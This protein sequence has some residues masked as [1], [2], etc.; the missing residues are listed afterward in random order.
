LDRPRLYAVA[1][2]TRCTGVDVVAQW[3]H[4]ISRCAQ[5]PLPSNSKKRSASRFQPGHFNFT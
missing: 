3:A 4:V 5:R 1:A 2:H